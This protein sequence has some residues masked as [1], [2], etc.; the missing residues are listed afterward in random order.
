L[1]HDSHKEDGGDGELKND[2]E[3]SYEVVDNTHPFA[4]GYIVL[5]CQ[6]KWTILV[7]NPYYNRWNGWVD[8]DLYP[9]YQ[10]F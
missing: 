9:L 4:D 3:R 10:S 6:G 2:A 5:F 1:H 8:I 7:F